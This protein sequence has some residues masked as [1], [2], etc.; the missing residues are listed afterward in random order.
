MNKERAL[1]LAKDFI[2]DTIVNNLA[3]HNLNEP[4]DL[5]FNDNILE[6]DPNLDI[7]KNEL[8]K[9]GYSLNETSTNWFTLTKN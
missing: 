2:E 5:F 1:E 8:S 9:V 7:L 6:N 3:N 4:I